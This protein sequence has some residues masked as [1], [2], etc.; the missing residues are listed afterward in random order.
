MVGRMRRVRGV[1]SAA[2]VPRNSDGG[3]GTE[4]RLKRA[5]LAVTARM[6]SAA[7]VELGIVIAGTNLV[8]A[9]FGPFELPGLF[10]CHLAATSLQRENLICRSCIC[11]SEICMDRVRNRTW[12][13]GSVACSFHTLERF[14]C[15]RSMHGAFSTV[16]QSTAYL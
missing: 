14:R 9:S 2:A 3:I 6:M 11:E 5:G 4:R 12:N 15:I 13:T 1:Q 10:L 7:T 8:G 16:G